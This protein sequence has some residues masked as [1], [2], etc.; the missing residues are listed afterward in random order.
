MACTAGPAADSPGTIDLGPGVARSLAQHRAR[1]IAY[2]RYEISLSIPEAR[3]EPIEG[4]ITARFDLTATGEPLVFDFAAAGAAVLSVTAGGEPT[5]FETV[6]EHVIVPASHLRQGANEVS[7]AFVAGDG[8]LNR[9]D[10]FLYTLFV[11][12]R[13]RVAMPIFD[14]PDLKARFQLTLE[15]PVA[16]DAGQ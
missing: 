2:L 16:W 3:D 12:D 11:P 4:V 1:T 5:P 10:E 9:A 7:I 8:S 14:Q 15:L 6:D 13:A